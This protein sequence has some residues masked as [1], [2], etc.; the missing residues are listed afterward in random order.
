MVDEKAPLR[1]AVACPP[2]IQSDSLDSLAHLLNVQLPKHPIY[3]IL[4]S[5]LFAWNYV[6]CI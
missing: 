6:D 4:F 2:S 1:T 3:F 5:P